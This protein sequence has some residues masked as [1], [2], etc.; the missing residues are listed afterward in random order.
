MAVKDQVL[1]RN[2]WMATFSG[3]NDDDML[4]Y[5]VKQIRIV[6]RERGYTVYCRIGRR[7]IS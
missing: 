6:N 7:K 1:G 4:D 2:G 5:I 3:E